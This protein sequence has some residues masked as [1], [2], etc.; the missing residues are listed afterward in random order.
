M[1]RPIEVSDLNGQE[2]RD[3]LSWAY[4]S[5]PQLK[6]AHT[7]GEHLVAFAGASLFVCVATLALHLGGCR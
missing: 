2:S 3:A 5:H 6:R 1:E 7:A 4:L